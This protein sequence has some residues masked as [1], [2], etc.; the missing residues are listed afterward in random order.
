MNATATNLP[1]QSFWLKVPAVAALVFCALSA[2]FIAFWNPKTVA[3]RY[4]TV[5]TSALEAGDFRRALVAGQRLLEIAPDR[6]SSTILLL[7]RANLGIGDAREADGLLEI[8]APLEKPVFAPAHLFAA[9][10]L[11]DLSSRSN[12]TDLAVLTQIS[13]AL[14]LVPDSAEANQLL[15]R[16]HMQRREWAEARTALEK[17]VRND[18]LSMFDLI[19]VSRALRDDEAT[20]LWSDAARVHFKQQFERTGE[21][22]VY[23]AEAL[24]QNRDFASACELIASE[25][26]FDTS[27]AAR[28]QY[29]LVCEAWAGD[30]AKSDPD[31]ISLRSQVIADGLEKDP[32]NVRLRS[33]REALGTQ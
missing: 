26:G 10:S 1:S 5:A 8:I 29:A 3:A 21:G 16:L 4:E 18:P 23:Y 12:Q 20:R 28:R 13:H 24:L 19:T 22:R 15:A 6:R 2:I 7:V 11:L 33:L 25:T 30:L 14:A 27:V 31:D 32:K 17:I 9:R